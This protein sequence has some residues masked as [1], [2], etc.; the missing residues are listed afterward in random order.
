[1]SKQGE[2]NGKLKK[3]LDCEGSLRVRL[4]LEL[5]FGTRGL[6]NNM[7]MVDELYKT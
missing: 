2:H 3:Y 4:S 6:K 7:Y 1:M 5:F